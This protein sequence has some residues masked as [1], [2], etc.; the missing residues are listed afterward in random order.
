MKNARGLK[1]I[2]E[3]AALEDDVQINRIAPFLQVYFKGRCRRRVARK[4]A[5]LVL[6]MLQGWATC[7]QIIMAQRMFYFRCRRLQNWWRTYRDLM[8]EFNGRVQE[9]FTEAERKLCKEIFEKDEKMRKKRS[10]TQNANKPKVRSSKITLSAAERI[11]LMMTPADVVKNFLTQEMRVYRFRHLA[12]L[13]AHKILYAQY[14]TDMKEYR[15][16]KETA[17]MLGNEW[18]DEDH[19]RPELPPFPVMAITDEEID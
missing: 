13:A 8:Y 6:E 10:V 2:F 19:E 4:S 16:D 15:D 11:K 14:C 17:R 12:K 7:G 9:R 3:L 5:A 1:K 18:K